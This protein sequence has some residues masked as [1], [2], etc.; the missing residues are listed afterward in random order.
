MDIHE[1]LETQ[2]PEASVQTFYIFYPDPW[3]KRR[4]HCRRLINAEFLVLLH[5]KL[6]PDGHVHFA[7]DDLD[8][9]AA[10]TPVFLASPLFTPIA[11]FI[12]QPDEQT[13]FELLFAAVGKHANRCSVQAIN[14]PRVA[15]PEPPV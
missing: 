15:A 9:F 1:A 8:Y 10:A 2:I 12:P 14:T 6:R 5:R 7:T 13:D 4:H 3:P 11:P